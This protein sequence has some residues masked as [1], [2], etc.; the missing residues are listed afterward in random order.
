MEDCLMIQKILRLGR[1]TK[2]LPY[3]RGLALLQRF[4][5]LALPK[6]DMQLSVD[7]FDNDLKLRVDVR[8]IIGVNV[9]HRPKFFNK[10]QR[11]L[12]CAAITP[13]SVVLD[14]G[15]NV[16]VY[17]LLAAK[18]GARVF[19]IEADPRN[20]K[21]LR[22][23]VHLNGFDDRVTI[24]PIAV[25]DQEGTVTLFHSEGNCG[26]SNLFEGTDPVQVPCQKIDSLGLPA[27]DV[28]K[29]DI[30]GSELR[31]LR[32]MDETI[33]HSPKMKM[34]VEYAEVLGETV[35]LFEFICERFA[36]VYAIRHPPFGA[37]GPLSAGQKL[38]RFCDL[39]AV[40]NQNTTK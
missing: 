4:Y 18:L 5:Q 7:D 23:H 27:I 33:K 11:K 26:H 17:T 16:G 36:P 12:F 19:A 29:M 30:E 37:M 10:N 13:G 32:G 31:A 25:G 1:I 22:H 34:L 15:A 6:G 8:D 35:G 2:Y 20:L 38:P 9:W 40:R 21:M 39:W 3:F 14:V 24:F 28:C